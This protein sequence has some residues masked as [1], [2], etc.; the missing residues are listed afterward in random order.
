M[1]ALLVTLNSYILSRF[2]ASLT[3]LLVIGDQL[4]TGVALD[5]MGR[6]VN[7]IKLLCV[8]WF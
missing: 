5:A 2:D 6:R 8:F 4:L 1:S 7:A 3:A